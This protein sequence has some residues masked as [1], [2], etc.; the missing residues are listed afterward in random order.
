[1]NLDIYSYLN[2]SPILLAIIIIWTMIWKGLALWKSVKLNSK[3]W[4]IALFVINT[5]GILEI[6]YLFVF[7]KVNYAKKKKGK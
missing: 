3:V 2:I 1:M 4:F 7:S 6:L 5:L